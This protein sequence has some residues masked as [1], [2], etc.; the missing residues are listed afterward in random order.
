MLDAV[1]HLF[2]RN[3]ISA[4][5]AAFFFHLPAK[6]MPTNQLFNLFNDCSH[7]WK[8]YNPVS[9]F[10][11]LYNQCNGGCHHYYCSSRIH[12]PRN[13]E[14]RRTLQVWKSV[15]YPHNFRKFEKNTKN[16]LERTLQV[17]T[18]MHMNLHATHSSY[19]LLRPSTVYTFW[20]AIIE[21]KRFSNQRF[22]AI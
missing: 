21:T 17:Y 4:A 5:G 6:N 12:W 7:F 14:N 2:S 16:R 10:K 22:V 15:N 9:Q 18:R 20:F 3:R 1:L 8:E 19:S 13:I 11:Y